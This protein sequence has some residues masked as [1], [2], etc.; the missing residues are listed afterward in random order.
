MKKI[1]LNKI[2][3]L[4]SSF[5][6]T[7]ISNFISQLRTEEPVFRQG[8]QLDTQKSFITDRLRISSNSGVR[9][10]RLVITKT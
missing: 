7:Q 3:I 4:H 10:H 2:T 1:I 6:F 5:K 9:K 8:R